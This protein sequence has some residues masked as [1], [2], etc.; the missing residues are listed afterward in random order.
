MPEAT[1]TVPVRGNGDSSK[2]TGRGKPRCLLV[3]LFDTL[4]KSCTLTSQLCVEL[5]NPLSVS[6]CFC[7]PRAEENKALQTLSK[8]LGRTD[9]LSRVRASEAFCE[10][11]KDANGI[12]AMLS[13]PDLTAVLPALMRAARDDSRQ[14]KYFVFCTM[15]NLAETADGA[16]VLVKF[17]APAELLRC[18]LAP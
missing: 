6:S 4:F 1:R 18:V 11:A 8:S 7:G 13:E 10:A 15:A 12:A 9:F 2:C 14:V 16:R 3:Y 17:G 5:R